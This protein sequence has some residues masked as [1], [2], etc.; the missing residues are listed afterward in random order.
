VR[1]IKRQHG[2]NIVR[3]KLDNDPECAWLDTIEG[4]QVLKRRQD[5]IELRIQPSVTPNTI[6]AEAL[7]QNGMV[8]LFEL[9]EPSLTDIFIARVGQIALP[10]APSHSA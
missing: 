6:L 1:E 9:V 5:Y 7:R 3:I 8:T 4:V 10:D 2:R